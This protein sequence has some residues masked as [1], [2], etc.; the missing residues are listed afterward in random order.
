MVL[1]PEVESKI[2]GRG[3]T[4]EWQLDCRIYV[5]N[6][7]KLSEDCE[8]PLLCTVKSL[9]VPCVELNDPQQEGGRTN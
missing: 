9:C 5:L 6:S 3:L 2:F 1:F 4:W 7:M 8:L